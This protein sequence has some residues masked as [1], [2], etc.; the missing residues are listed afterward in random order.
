M[1]LYCSNT[2][3]LCLQVTLITTPSGAEA[4][5]L[6]QDLPVSIMASPTSEEPGS[7]TSTATTTTAGAEA[8]D[9]AAATGTETSTTTDT[10]TTTADTSISTSYCTRYTKTTTST[11]VL[12]PQCS[13]LL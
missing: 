13:K 2:V 4:Q 10:N 5:P 6:V 7:T 9:T 12:P 1:S 8:G 11:A 3:V